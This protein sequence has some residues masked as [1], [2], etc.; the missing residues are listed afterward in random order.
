[1]IKT[2][3]VRWMPIALVVVGALMASG[4]A[5]VPSGQQEA[6]SISNVKTGLMAK[7]GKIWRIYQEGSHFDYLSNAECNVKGSRS[8][9][10]WWGYTFDYANIQ[11]GTKLNC[12]NLF[13]RPQRLVDRYFDYGFV[14]E[15]R[16]T[17]TLTK[18][19]GTYRSAGYQSPIDEEPG[20]LSINTICTI[21]DKTV[22]NVTKSV[23][24]SAAR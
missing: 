6:S 14:I 22:I 3:N 7:R 23:T 9:C 4:C 15:S 18:T 5:S 24:F 11:R 17:I 21:Q 2:A 12:V 19:E 20:T 13:S 16:F 1:M 10:M 8:P